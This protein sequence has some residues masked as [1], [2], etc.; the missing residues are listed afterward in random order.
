MYKV[1]YYNNSYAYPIKYHTYSILD[2]F[3]DFLMIRCMIKK[4]RY[5]Q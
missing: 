2:M 4:Y 3:K 5:Y 1:Y